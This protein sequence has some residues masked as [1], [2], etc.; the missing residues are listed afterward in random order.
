[1]R[2]RR[3]SS[4]LLSLMV[5]CLGAALVL[6]A[7]PAE[8]TPTLQPEQETP[9][10]PPVH[11]PTLKKHA[12][13]RPPARFSSGNEIVQIGKDIVVKAGE[14]VRQVVV[15]AGNAVI[16][17]TVED[18]LVI[19][20]GSAQVNGQVGRDLV[21]VLG[22]ATLGPQ[23]Q[24]GHDLV[25]V[26]GPL[27]KNPQATV[28]GKE[29]VVVLGHIM[30]N[31][32]WLQGWLAKGLFLAR[33]FPP[34]FKWAW[35][36]AALLLVVYLAL[37]ALFPTAVRASVETLERQPV[38]SFFS[39]ILLLVSFLPIVILLGISVLGLPII[40][41]AF[42][43][44][45]GA[46]FLG[47]ATVF[48]YAGQQAG[49]QMHIPN[50]GLPVL[51]ILGAV[52]FSVLYMVPVLGFAVWGMATLIGVGAVLLAAF[53]SFRKNRE[54]AYVPAMGLALA[55][56]PGATGV[57]MTAPAMPPLLA[58]TDIVLLPRVG[59][60]RRLG[61]TILDFVLLGALI[62]FAGPLFLVVWA[63]YHVGMWAWKGTT[64][65]GIVLNI[66]IVRADGRPI[67]F[68][69]ALIRCLASFFSAFALFLGFFWAGWDRERQ[70]WHDKIAGTV[71]VRVPRGLSL[72]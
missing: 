53:G 11:A 5:A 1:M 66:K 2:R 22:S 20:S 46:V 8:E 47:K 38:A 42:C 52:L 64:V 55:Q 3:L 58:P 65:G 18:D 51:L 31:F 39:G 21:T 37:T 14:S 28:D 13:H 7:E 60:W 49:R 69:V 29:T 17:G 41:F 59:F 15:I 34:E 44:L 12:H 10:P 48:T 16:D 56:A 36:V 63:A 62:P 23:A 72:I 71:V 26:G 40:P 43:L 24:I 19:V 9:P 67:D 45:L 54:P 61:A 27:L 70:A 32:V 33:P 4:F 35:I 30:P 6:G 25:V 50:L 68:A 57:S